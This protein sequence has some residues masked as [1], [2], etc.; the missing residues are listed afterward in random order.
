MQIRYGLMRAFRRA[1]RRFGSAPPSAAAAPRGAIIGG[2]FSRRHLLSLPL[3]ALVA[4][5]AARAQQRR[6]MSDPL[7]LGVELALSDSGL[8]KA[9]LQGF[10]RDTGIA[11]LPVPAPALPLLEGLERGEFDAA[12]SNAPEA[13]TR[14]VAQGL[15][16][17]RRAIARGE[18]VIV[19]PAPRGKDKDPA[20]IAGLHTAAEALFQVRSAALAMPGVVTFLT[21][22]DGSGAHAIEQAL[23]RQAALAPG[24]PWYAAADPK[25]GLIPQARARG[26]Y[27]LVERAAW[28]VHGGAPLA[29][30]V[31]ADPLLAEQVHVMRAFR[32]THPA[33]KLFVAWV[34]GPKGRRIVAA[35]RGYRAA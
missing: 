15:A 31:D 16:H 33:G 23:W 10:G 3:G 17:D 30:L 11:V 18:F 6:S 35:Q 14:L 4:P 21:A 2:M 28:A 24:A 7:R 20:A 5:G 19:G 13:E 34:G 22:A 29:V 9:L 1:G 8:A 25:I 26:A 27:A 12:L 32:A